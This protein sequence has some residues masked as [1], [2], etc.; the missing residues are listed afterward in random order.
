MQTVPDEIA[1]DVVRQQAEMGWPDIVPAYAEYPLA[2]GRMVFCHFRNLTVARCEQLVEFH[3]RR[4]LKA[5]ATW[6]KTHSQA[7]CRKAAKNILRARLYRCQYIT[8]IGQTDSSEV[9]MPFANWVI[10]ETDYCNG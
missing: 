4:A 5:M 8:L 7:A 10:E 3:T 2:D 6:R 9:D 1:I